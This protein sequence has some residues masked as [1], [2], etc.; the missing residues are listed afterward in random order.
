M[1]SRT[2]VLLSSSSV[3]PE[4][5]AAAFEMAATLG[6]DGV[7]VMV[8]TDAVSQDAGALQGLAAHYGVPVLVGARALPA[9]DPAGVELRPVGAAAPRRGARRDARGARPW[10][11]TRRSP[12]SATTP[13][14]FAPGLERIARHHS[15]LSV[16]DRE[17]VP[18][19]DGRPRVRALPAGLGSD[20]DRLRRVHAGPVALRGLAHRRARH[21]R[22]DGRRASS[23]C[24]SAT[25]P[26]RG[27]TS[28]WCPGR[29]NQPCGELLESLAGRGFRGSVAVEVT[30]RGAKSRAVREADL[31]AALEFARAP[32][33]RTGQRQGETPPAIPESDDA[34]CDPGRLDAGERRPL[35]GPVCRHVRPGRAPLRAEAPAVVGR[36][37]EVDVAAALVGADAEPGAAVRAQPDRQAPDRAGQVLGADRRA[38]AGH[39]HVP[40]AGV[41]A[42]DPR[43]H[44]MGL[45]QRV[46]LVDGLGVAAGA[47]ELEDVA[48]P[49]LGTAERSSR[50]A[51]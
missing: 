43:L 5:T 11:C 1:T 35:A 10:S 50:R 40:V 47:A 19:A 4:P 23:T 13:G 32:P 31:Q 27:A 17:H 12:G 29:G 42:G 41:V 25:A 20:R 36:R 48:Q 26:A 15:D 46:E 22:H 38:A 51:R 37:V 44:R 30:T 39:V 9:G 8:W 2:P 3:F 21:G 49:L 34:G 16:R 14:S 28:T 6:Y 33:A 24:T 45:E 7:E 18:G